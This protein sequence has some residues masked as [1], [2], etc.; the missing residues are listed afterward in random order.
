MLETRHL[1]TLIALAEAGNLSVAAKRVHLTQSALSHQL[2]TLEDHYG[3]TL[4]ERKSQP[5][6]LSP[7]GQRL[8]RLAREITGL[9]A[10]ADTDVARIVGGRAGELRI[11]V[12]CHTCFD[13]LMPSMDAFRGHWPEVEM[14]L[15]SGFHPDPVGLLEEARADF[16]ITSETAKRRNIV[17][18]PLFRYEIFALLARDHPLAAK[19]WLEPEDFAKHT[20]ITYPVPEHMIDLIRQRLEPAGIHPERRTVE[21]TV[22]LLQ[23]VASRRGVA[24]LAGWAVHSYIERGY[25]AA[26]RIGKDGLWSK[27]YAATTA[28]TAQLPYLKDFLATV[29]RVSFATLPEILPLRN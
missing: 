24:A 8:L 19:Q 27:L 29:R 14:D 2:K 7:A 23:L 28:A 25:V 18:H 5:L 11:A 10:A 6:R 9:I 1:R 26:R 21:L 22:A 4:F 3:T 12:E 15:V 17:Y 16:V 13:W 20:L